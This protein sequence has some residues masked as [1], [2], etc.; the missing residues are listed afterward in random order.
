MDHTRVDVLYAEML[1]LQTRTTVENVYSKKKI[2]MDALKLLILERR[3]QIYF[4]N[5]K[6][7]GL[8]KDSMSSLSFQR[9]LFLS[10][11]FLLP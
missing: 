9:S 2:G 4:M 8:K 5:E 7:M 3:K 1:G 10:S 6:N 11:K